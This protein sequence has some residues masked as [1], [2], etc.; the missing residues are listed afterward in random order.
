MQNKPVHQQRSKEVTLVV[1]E[2]GKNSQRNFKMIKFQLF[3]IVKHIR[4]NA[5]H[6]KIE[7]QI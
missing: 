3:D 6:N 4:H 1:Q 2:K 5:D 7:Y